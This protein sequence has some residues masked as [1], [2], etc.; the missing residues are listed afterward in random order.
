MNK[1]IYFYDN[2]VIKYAENLKPSYRNELEITDINNKYIEEK[3]IDYYLIKPG[4]VWLDAGTENSLL[5]ASS[6][7]QT[8]Q[9]RQNIQISSPEIIALKNGWTSKKKIMNSI[10][11]LNNSYTSFIKNL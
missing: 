5:Q 2:E 7:M 10:K 3:K 1:W 4:G 6:Y 11:Y 8:I 9:N